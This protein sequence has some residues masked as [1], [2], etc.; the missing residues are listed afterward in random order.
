MRTTT[1]QV[2]LI[3]NMAGAVKDIRTN[4]KELSL[5]WTKMAGSGTLTD[6]LVKALQSTWTDIVAN[7]GDEVTVLNSL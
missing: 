5:F 3:E 4:S 1:E 6:Q 2:S 7:C